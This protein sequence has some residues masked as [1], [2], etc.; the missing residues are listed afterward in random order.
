MAAYASQSNYPRVV[1]TLA[2]M[3]RISAAI[4]RPEEHAAYVEALALK[5]K[6]KRTFIRLLNDRASSS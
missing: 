3:E 4:G 1:A 5:H 6:A 2:R